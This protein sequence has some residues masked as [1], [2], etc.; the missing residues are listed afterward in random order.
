MRRLINYNNLIYFFNLFWLVESFIFFLSKINFNFY[1]I[2]NN[3]LKKLNENIFSL[4]ESS[5]KNIWNLIVRPILIAQYLKFKLKSA[6]DL[7]LQV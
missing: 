6:G 2:N 4:F 7:A 3:R 5:K 1:F